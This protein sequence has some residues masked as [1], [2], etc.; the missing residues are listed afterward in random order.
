M[1][2]DN[3]TLYEKAKFIADNLYDKPSAYKSGFIVKTYKELGG[4]YSGKKPNKT[5]IARWFKEEWK[6]IG[7][8]EY[9]VY[10]PTKRI[11]KDTPLTPKEIK[12]SNLRSQIA[13]KQEIKG[14][15][16][17]PAFQGKGIVISLGQPTD[18]ISQYDEIY[19]WSNPKKVQELAKN[20]LGEG[21]TIFRSIKKDKKYMI[22]NPNTKKW[23]HFGQIGY[24]DF[25][26]HKDEVR[27]KNYLTR[28]ANMKGNW[29]DDKYSAN[30]LSRNILW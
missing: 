20:Y 4:T 22:Y 12:P 1:N 2:I 21:A 10:R 29:K 24:E 26:K 7:N 3:P 14:D 6:D 8:L 15:A 18:N 9:P 17:L 13:L 16:N 11:T 5:G 23:V 28:T 30:N 27:R 19:K 25:T